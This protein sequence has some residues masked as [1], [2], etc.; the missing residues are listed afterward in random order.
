MEEFLFFFNYSCRFT[1]APSVVRYHTLRHANA[2]NNSFTAFSWHTL[3][4]SI[5]NL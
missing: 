4:F 3:Q 1:S 5:T 2:T